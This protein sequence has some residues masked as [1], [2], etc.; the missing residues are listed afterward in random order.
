MLMER[1]QLGLKRQNWQSSRTTH[2]S[3]IGMPA[4]LAHESFKPLHATVSPIPPSIRITSSE[5]ILLCFM[6]LTIRETYSSRF[7]GS[8]EF[9]DPRMGLEA[10]SAPSLVEADHCQ[11]VAR[12]KG[13]SPCR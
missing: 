2:R 9:P 13:G 7:S 4:S 11:P 5:P 1:P 12:G 6:A 10:V 3:I 8:K